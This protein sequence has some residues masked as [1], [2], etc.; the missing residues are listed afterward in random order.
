MQQLTLRSK[1]L[2]LSTTEDPKFKGK[3]KKKKKKNFKK[4]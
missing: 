1:N 4:N 2:T 3:K